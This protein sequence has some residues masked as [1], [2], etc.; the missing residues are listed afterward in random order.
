LEIIRDMI[1][2]MRPSLEQFETEIFRRV[3]GQSGPGSGANQPTR[4]GPTTSPT[5]A[6]QV[7]GRE[8][9]APPEA[10]REAERPKKGEE[11]WVV[12]TAA[13][14][15]HFTHYVLNNMVYRVASL[16]TRGS[17]PGMRMRL[18]E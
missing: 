7:T 15:N 12:P 9:R 14:R 11:E 5:T 2:D 6:V 16:K 1:E 18:T 17:R 13:A 4:M 8:D 10:H 3:M